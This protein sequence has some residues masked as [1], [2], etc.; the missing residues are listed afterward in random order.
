MTA[1]NFDML[2]SSVVLTVMLVIATGGLHL[3]GLADTFDALG[4]GKGSREE[5]LSVM[6]DPH[7]GVMGVLA[8]TSALSVKTSLLFSVPAPSKTAALILM[9]ALSRWSL[10]FVIYSFPYAR[11]AGK[12]KV[13]FDGIS[14]RLLASATAMAA[15]LSFLAFGLKGFLIL[16]MAA[17]V[18]YAA[19]R[20]INSKIGGM[21]GDTLG[22]VNELVE[23]AVLFSIYALG[24]AAPV[25]IQ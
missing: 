20:F 24:H 16:G 8:V 21:T 2:F 10:V 17:A 4:S 19:G 9:C 25:L 22:A 15:V 5:M 14:L 1:L 7:I 6:R 18:S 23:V 13:F 3:D 11:Q 12:A